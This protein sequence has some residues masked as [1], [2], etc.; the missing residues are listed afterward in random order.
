MNESP[1]VWMN[2]GVSSG[3]EKGVKVTIFSN[4]SLLFPPF[5]LF[6]L[7]Q[8]IRLLLDFPFL[9]HSASTMKLI[10]FSLLK[11][12]LCSSACMFARKSKI[13]RF[14]F[15][16]CSQNHKMCLLQPEKKNISPPI[17][18]FNSFRSKTK[19]SP[20]QKSLES[21]PR[22]HK[23]DEKVFPYSS[24]SL[25]THHFSHNF[26]ASHDIFCW[27]FYI[28]FMSFAHSSLFTSR[29]GESTRPFRK[30]RARE[31]ASTS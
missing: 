31:P 22:C 15:S 30:R 14:S 27:C 8:F 29:L 28:N 23:N 13:S 9:C 25:S 20:T 3:N 21:T 18:H 19:N 17:F 24:L 10:I 1:S 7:C 26:P 4:F 6:L 2:E 5:P 16:C 12:L 11:C